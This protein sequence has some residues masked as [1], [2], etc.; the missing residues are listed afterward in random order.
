VSRDA[1][2]LEELP[3]R[4]IFARPKSRIL[5]CPRSVTKMLAGLISL[6][7]LDGTVQDANE[8][9]AVGAMVELIPDSLSRKIQQRFKRNDH[10]PI[11]AISD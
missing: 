7:T 8:L 6:G 5:A 1:K 10:Q 9:P 4:L 3:A 2:L 11:W